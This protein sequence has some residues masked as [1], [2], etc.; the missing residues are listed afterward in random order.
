LTFFQLGFAYTLNTGHGFVCTICTN[1]FKMTLT[2]VTAQMS[3][4]TTVPNALFRTRNLGQHF[5][6]ISKKKDVN[7]SLVSLLNDIY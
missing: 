7:Q 3:L 6:D 2:A 4:K 5:L 1:I